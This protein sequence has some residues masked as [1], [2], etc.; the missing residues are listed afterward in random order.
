MAGKGAL[1]ETE[2]ESELWILPMTSNMPKRAVKYGV[3]IGRVSNNVA[4]EKVM[5]QIP[6]QLKGNDAG[7]RMG[8]FARL[9]LVASYLEGLGFVLDRLIYE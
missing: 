6:T 5:T 3:V 9:S 1:G 8:Y 2:N 7:N 4:S